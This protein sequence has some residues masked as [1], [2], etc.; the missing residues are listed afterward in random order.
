MIRPCKMTPQTHGRSASNKR[1]GSSGTTLRHDL[2]ILQL[3]IACYPVPTV[4]P[5]VVA[6]RQTLNVWWQL[7]K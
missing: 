7:A 6:K 2:G 1:H 4:Q 3:S 5:M